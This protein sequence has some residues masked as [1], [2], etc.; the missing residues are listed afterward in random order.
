MTT[1]PITRIVKSLPKLAKRTGPTPDAPKTLV[2]IRHTT[3]PEPRK[4]VA[5]AVREMGFRSGFS[6]RIGGSEG[7]RR[8][9]TIGGIFKMHVG[10]RDLPSATA[11]MRR[12]NP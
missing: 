11:I 3:L 10:D 5:G 2:T 4:L 6:V 9:A 7:F 1:D 8:I 12:L